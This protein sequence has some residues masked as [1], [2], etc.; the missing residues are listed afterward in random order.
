MATDTTHPPATAEQDQAPPDIETMRSSVRRALLDAP[1]MS[2]MSELD[3][4]A[5]TLR[6]HM[7]VL[8]PEVAAAAA[9]QPQDGIPRHCALA[10]VGEAR[11]KLG[12]GNGETLPVRVAVTQKLARSVNALCDHIEILAGKLL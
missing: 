8:I 12:I 3:T 7:Q 9:R 10:C 1:S 5:R 4:L 2:G 6:G 11:R